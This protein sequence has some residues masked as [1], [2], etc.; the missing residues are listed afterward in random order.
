[1]IPQSCKRQVQQQ[2]TD[3]LQRYSPDILVEKA[4]ARHGLIVLVESLEQA[5]KLVNEVAPQSLLLSVAEPWEIAEKVRHAGTIFLG[6]HTPAAIGDYVGGG[7][8][9]GPAAETL[10]QACQVGVETFLKSFILLEHSV[11]SLL[12]L[13]PA[14]AALAEF[15]ARPG[16][17]ESLQ[18]RRDRPPSSPSA[19]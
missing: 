12:A 11:D 5:V 1:M 18:V 6:H 17:V 2:V 13:S 10:Y 4:I 19:F 3:R 16:T 8:Q 9:R 14:L 15:D 7:L